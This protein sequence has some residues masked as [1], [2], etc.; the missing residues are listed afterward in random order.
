MLGAN[1]FASNG[2]LMT[3]PDMP[4][5]AARVAGAGR[6][7]RR[8]RPA[9]HEDRRRSRRALS[10]S[11]PR[12]DALFLFA[13]VHVL[14]A[15][16]LVDLGTVADA[17]RTGSTRCGA[18]AAEFTPETRRAGVRDRRGNHPPDRAR[19]RGR[20]DGRGVRRASARARRS[21][22]RSRRGSSTSSTCCTGNLDRPGGAMFTLAATGADRAAGRARAA[23]CASGAARRACAACPSSSASCPVVCLAEEIE[24]PGDGQIRALDHDRGQPRAVDARTPIGSTVRSR[25]LDF[26]VSVDIYVNET[27]RHAERDPA[28]RAG[29]RRAV[30]TT[31]RSTTSRSA[32]S[33]TTRRRSSTSS[34]AR[35]PSG[36][37]MLRLARRAQRA[38]RE[39]RRRR[40]RRLR[41]RRDSCRRP[42]AQG[43]RNVEGRDADEMMKELAPRRGPERM[44][45]F[46]LRT[47][48]YGDGFGADPDGLSLAVL[49]A[50]PHGIDLGPLQPR[51]PEVLRTRDG[52]DRAR[53]RS[54]ASTDVERLRAALDRRR[55]RRARSCSSAG[56]ICAR[57]TR[58]C[59]TSTCS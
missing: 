57:T 58:G 44:L 28:A 52:H 7:A 54:R 18:L 26:M 51:I 24:T 31:S 3:A 5:P 30:T 49:E 12:T 13:I 39:R 59:T 42:C 32:T 25:T 56:A 17:R 9:A 46:M 4:G 40:A 50:N 21:S 23:A 8:R 35:C 10:R 29:A 37:T 47:G 53:A 43:R 33:R 27:T 14:F 2:S 38:G 6:Q 20:A 48:P 15:D 1:P 19:A 55:R 45:D 41:R 16:D 22:A 34:P 36:S 11:G